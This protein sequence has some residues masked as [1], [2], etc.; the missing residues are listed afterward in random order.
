MKLR[1]KG[2]APR[3][4]ELVSKA[5]RAGCVVLACTIVYSEIAKLRR[6]SNVLNA[7]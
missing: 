3:G 1:G 7:K 4:N 5:F 2:R 6:K